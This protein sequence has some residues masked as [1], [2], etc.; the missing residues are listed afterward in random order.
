M[1]LLTKLAALP[2]CAALAAPAC[3][4]DYATAS[5]AGSGA[6][7]SFAL[8]ATDTENAVLAVRWHSAPHARGWSWA[9]AGWATGEGGLWAGAGV[10]YTWALGASAWFVRGS[11]MPG[12]YHQGDE[13]DLGGPVEFATALELGRTLA[14]GAELSM[15]V[16]HRSNA[17]LYSHNPG[18]NTLSVVYTLPLR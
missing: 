14:N 18:L 3:A 15:M 16:E 1:S 13:R 4:Q 17:H 5:T 2:L 10:S 12:L 6:R 7:L 9:A 8:G 11:F